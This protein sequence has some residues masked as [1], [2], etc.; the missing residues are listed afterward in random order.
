MDIKINIDFAFVQLGTTW[1]Q[2]IV[3]LIMTNGDVQSAMKEKQDDRFPFIEAYLP[4]RM[5]IPALDKVINMKRPRLIKT[6]LRA[7]FFEGSFAE[8]KPK[9]VVVF[10]NPKD[11]LVSY[12]HFYTKLEVMGYFPGTF[13]DFFELYKKK[14]IVHGDPFDFSIGWWKHKDEENCFFT[15]YEEMKK[16][17]RA[18][19]RQVAAF[20]EKELSDE[21]VEAIVA[22][23]AFDQMKTNEMVNKSHSIPDFMRK[24]VVGDWANHFTEEQAKIVDEKEK[25]VEKEYGIKFLSS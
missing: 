24:G 11:C 12:Y 18:V 19:I 6:H 17:I 20:L 2:E 10:R 5:P 13:S 23:T 1:M 3:Y 4:E 7:H 21:V 25:E 15:S 14:R 22:H 16:D 9:V 8:V